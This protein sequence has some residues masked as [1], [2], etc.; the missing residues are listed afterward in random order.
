M[1]TPESSVMDEYAPL[2]IMAAYFSCVC[3]IMTG[4]AY[5]V[6]RFCCVHIREMTLRT[7]LLDAQGRVPNVVESI[8]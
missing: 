8:N 1:H 5:A 6:A 7:R 2:Y 3:C 4:A